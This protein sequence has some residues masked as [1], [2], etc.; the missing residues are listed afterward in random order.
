MKKFSSATALLL[1][2]IATYWSYDSLMPSYTRVDAS[3][4]EQ[5]FSTTKALNHVKQ[6]S[7]KPHAVGF[8]A[9]KDF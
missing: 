2:I 1:I 8:K 6:I 4:A 3:E 9:H 5:V 7:Q